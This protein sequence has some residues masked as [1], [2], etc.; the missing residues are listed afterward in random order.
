SEIMQH[1]IYPVNSLAAFA[2]RFD[3]SYADLVAFAPTSSNQT[4]GVSWLLLLS[5]IPF[6]GRRTIAKFTPIPQVNS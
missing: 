6:S 1:F 4:T 5:C 2:V 3:A